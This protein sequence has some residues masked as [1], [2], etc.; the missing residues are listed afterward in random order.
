M[1]GRRDAAADDPESLSD[2]GCSMLPW[3]S[4][5]PMVAA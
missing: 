5:R 1:N 3:L 4:F 2:C